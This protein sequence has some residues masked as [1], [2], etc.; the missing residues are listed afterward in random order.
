MWVVVVVVVR[1]DIMYV[2]D[3]VSVLVKS[4]FI[5]IVIVIIDFEILKVFWE[6]WDFHERF[7]YRMFVHSSQ[8]ISIHFIPLQIITI[9]PSR[10][11]LISFHLTSLSSPTLSFLS[12]H[13]P[14][15][16]CLFLPPAV[17]LIPLRFPT[18]PYPSLSPTNQSTNQSPNQ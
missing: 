13:L 4:V 1:R 6:F 16:S 11:L 5:I 15:Y 12:S 7:T 8:F 3:V 9:Y 18:V 10:L 17:H 14:Y 2:L